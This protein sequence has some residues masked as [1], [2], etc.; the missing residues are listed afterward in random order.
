MT[1]ILD[2]IIYYYFMFKLFISKICDLFTWDFLSLTFFR[3][4]QNLIYT[5]IVTTVIVDIAILHDS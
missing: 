2:I 4:T 3:Y 5:M 1:I